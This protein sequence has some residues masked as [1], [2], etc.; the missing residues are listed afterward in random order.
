MIKKIALRAGKFP[1][2][3]YGLHQSAIKNINATNAGNMVFSETAHKILS[4]PHVSIEPLGY[5][6]HKKD[7]AKINENF[8]IL[9]LPLANAFRIQWKNTL[10]EYT[11]FISRMKIPV[12]VMGVGIQT[13]FEYNMENL[14]SI[15][16]EV[17]DFV[18]AV[19]DRSPT[20]GVR[21]EATKIFL[22]KLGFSESYV[23]IIGCPSMYRYGEKFSI[24]LEKL[25]T[26]KTSNLAL[27]ITGPGF[28]RTGFKSGKQK[29]I[30]ILDYNINKYPQTDVILQNNY[31]LKTMLW[32]R[33]AGGNIEY[34]GVSNKS[35]NS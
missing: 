3:Y 20:I 2:K 32:G 5:D 30:N 10:K 6:I 13:D 23:T 25:K 8:D 19:L 7:P 29:I 15:K 26:N 24:D 12:V 1:T 21:G 33:K 16:G 17:K 4:T 9:V 34:D 31:S 35:K 11:Q 28:N 22:E 18:S 27:N 14:T